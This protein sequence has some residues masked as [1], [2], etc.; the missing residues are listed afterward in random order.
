M[1]TRFSQVIGIQ[2]ATVPSEAKSIYRVRV[3]LM[4]FVVSSPPVKGGRGVC[5]RLSPSKTPLFSTDTVELPPLTGGHSIAIRTQCNNLNAT[6]AP[7]RLGNGYF[8]S[9]LLG[10]TMAMTSSGMMSGTA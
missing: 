2:S 8:E 9:F 5:F 7:A 6:P 10:F 4:R 1:I 3:S